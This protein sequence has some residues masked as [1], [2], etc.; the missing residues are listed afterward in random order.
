MSHRT[1]QFLSLAEKQGAILPRVIG[2][3]LLGHSLMLTG[4]IAEGRAHYDQS[5]A[6][7][8][9]TVHRPLATRFGQDGRCGNPMLSVAGAVVAWLS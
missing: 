6:L 4:N 9:P 3:R 7:Y 1:A 8:D 2:H 5:V